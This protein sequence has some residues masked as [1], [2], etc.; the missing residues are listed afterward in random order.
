M[1]LPTR[2]I[3]DLNLQPDSEWHPEIQPPD[4]FPAFTSP[5]TLPEDYREWTV[6]RPE[7]AMQSMLDDLVSLQHGRHHDVNEDPRSC[8]S[9]CR[10]IV[11]AMWIAFIRRRFLNLLSVNT[12]VSV[13]RTETDF[14]NRASWAKREWDSSWHRGI[15][16]DLVN[17]RFILDIVQTEVAS[18][19]AALGLAQST[20]N[21]AQNAH[22]DEWETTGWESVLRLASTVEKM[23]EIF[24]QSYSQVATIQETKTSN[25]L[26]RSVNKITALAMFFLPISVI[27]GIFSMGGSFLPGE[28]KNWVFWAVSCPVLVL[29][30]FLLFTN[31][32]QFIE[33]KFRRIFSRHEAP[34]LPLFRG[35]GS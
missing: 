33:R 14:L 12:L 25:D 3:R 16:S 19:M 11:I 29:T 26:T 27:S 35:K 31:A 1:V 20:M 23:V 10:K 13:T 22:A 18:N 9:I 5:E 28:S 15:F 32:I 21:V 30:A 7:P 34:D 2:E 17:A 8:T 6:L 24:T 4:L